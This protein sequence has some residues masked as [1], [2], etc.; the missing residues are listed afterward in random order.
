MI[1]VNL[2]KA[3][4]KDVGE[5]SPA[6]GAERAEKKSK[7]KSSEKKAKK[8][9]PGNLVIFLVILALG[10]AFLLQKRS[11]SQERT[12]LAEARD[13]QQRL[14]PVVNKLDELEWQKQYLEIKVSLI[15]ALRTQQ[16]TAVRIM[17]EISRALPDWVWLTEVTEGK[18]GLSLKGRALSNVLISD[19]VRSLEGCGLFAAVGIVTTQQKTEGNNQFLE[20]TLTAA[21][22]P[23]V[24][25][26]PATAKTPEAK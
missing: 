19:Y 1:R 23:P 10:G 3:E 25:P 26:K 14:Q 21:L 6:P 2:L 12:L 18:T 17:D 15:L 20:F 5:R 22:P 9:P 7:A 13:E 11:L 24:P 4:S 8:T 16:G